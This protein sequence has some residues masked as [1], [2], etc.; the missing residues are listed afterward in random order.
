MWTN[1]GEREGEWANAGEGR[2]TVGVDGR[3]VEKGEGEMGGG[4]RRMGCSS[5]NS[6]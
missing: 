4:I 3:G 1:A 5:E 2:E 6:R